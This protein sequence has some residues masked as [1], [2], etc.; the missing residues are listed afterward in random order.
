[1]Q[2]FFLLLAAMPIKVCTQ[3]FTVLP[4]LPRGRDSYQKVGGGGGGGG[5]LQ[6]RIYRIL[7]GGSTLVEMTSQLGVV[8]STSYPGGSGGMSSQEILRN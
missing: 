2:I 5:G 8:Q 7:L 3:M 4:P 6:R 1:M